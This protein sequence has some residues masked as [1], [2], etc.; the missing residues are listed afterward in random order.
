MKKLQIASEDITAIVEALKDGHEVLIKPIK[1]G[2][3]ILRLSTK[4]ITKS[5]D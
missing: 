5:N 4:V 2:Y 3:K 1:D